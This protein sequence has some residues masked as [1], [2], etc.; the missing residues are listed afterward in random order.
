[1][2]IVIDYQGA[3]SS[4]SRDRGIGRYTQSFVQ[5]LAKNHKDHELIIALNG[6]FSEHIDNIRQQFD[7]LI[8]NDN[9]VTWTPPDNVDFLTEINAS[10]RKS[11][12]LIYEAFLCSLEPNII[13]ITSL[14]EGSGD[15]A[16]TS[17]KRFNP[18]AL[19]A[20]ILYDLIPYIY[21]DIY[22][23]NPA[24]AAWY[25]SKIKHIR[26]SDLLLTISESSRQEAINFLGFEPSSVSNIS[27]AIEPN[28]SPALPSAVDSERLKQHFNISR[29]FI[30][31][32]G[33]IDHRKNI[34][35]L[36]RG[37]SQL[38]ECVRQKYQLVI[39]CSVHDFIEDKLLQ[40]GRDNGLHLDDLIFTGFV[41]DDD[42]LRLY[43][44]CEVFIFPSWHEGFGLPALEAMACGKAVIGSNVSSIPEVIGRAD[45]LFEANNDQA[46]TSK[47]EEVLLNE[48][49]KLELEQHALVQAQKFSWQQTAKE[50]VSVLEASVESKRLTTP[51]KQKLKPRLA[52]VSPLPPARSGISDYSADLLPT[53][54]DF[55]TIDLI[56]D[57]ENVDT[58]CLPQQCLIRSTDWLIK[59]A[60]DYDRVIYHFGNS[61]FHKHMFH[62]IQRIPGVVVLH[63]FY[64]SGAVNYI[65][66][67]PNP[68]L[69][70]TPE[71]YRSAGYTAVYDRYK[72]P[73][74][75]YNHAV[76]DAYPCNLTVL[77]N[78]LGVIS[79]SEY[80]R[81]LATD[82]YGDSAVKGWHVL[83][84]LRNPIDQCKNAARKA[85]GIE[86]DEF[87]VCTFG[88]LHRNKL[89]KELVSSWLDS[90]IAKS[91]KC[92]LIF[93]GDLPNNNYKDELHLLL[94]QSGQHNITITG[95]TEKEEYQHYLAAT[96]LCIQLRRTSRGE[97]SA[98]VLD[99]LSHGKATLVNRN[100]SM[101]E[102]DDEAIFKIPDDF[103]QAQ[104]A[105]ALDKLY[106]N[107]DLRERLG[108]AGRGLLLEKHSPVVCGN[109]YHHVI[110]GIYHKPP[111]HSAPVI[112]AIAKELANNT[113]KDVTTEVAIAIN[114]SF[115]PRIKPRQCLIDISAIID[116]QHTDVETENQF[117]QLLKQWVLTHSNHYRIEPVY[118]K[119]NCLY[120][121]RAFT[122]ELIN[123][124]TDALKD[125]PVEYF[126][127][128]EL[129]TLTSSRYSPRLSTAFYQATRSAGV[130]QTFFCYDL[131]PNTSDS[132]PI[133]NSVNNVAQWLPI[134]A[135]ADNIQLLSH[136]DS[137]YIDEI[138]ADTPLTDKISQL[139]LDAPPQRYSSKIIQR[140]HTK[141]I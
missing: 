131:A 139:S 21:P 69:R 38:Q 7:G 11:A 55:Y 58:N 40:L 107:P 52:F 130:I 42:L 83:P 14:F 63:D 39:V 26:Q 132:S 33:G 51:Q 105:A 48:Q 90:S 93:V 32:T 19:V 82:W 77:N 128:D 12:E 120:Y 134:L 30:M 53:L 72:D 97:T 54:L 122:L 59:H 3:Q 76:M 81:N 47:L 138:A 49:F 6:R 135:L 29:P 84:L 9:I 103:T 137:D 101:D 75:K 129:V 50:A 87:I 35:G 110:E 70:F 64:L 15:D 108:Q 5:A 67:R 10:R 61:S 27:T 20:T 88:M 37:Y 102:I 28:F 66:T 118:E 31:Y 125:S 68:G 95:W 25:H 80:S 57:Q 1:M 92:R 98:A 123:C 116:S 43:R 109:K 96:D 133:K 124:P 46:I 114:K 104:L 106:H 136:S 8:E 44:S 94:E 100:G 22:L 36:I 126:Q 99:C 79:H 60:D 2:R 34:E 121:A 74:D 91:E 17:I 4:G 13:L 111:Q 141:E 71:L 73:S 119:N 18:D 115:P 16:V 23:V 85:L 65:D 89:N 112:K 56:I 117:Q 86:N 127:G 24:I 78:A 62:L 113:N 41:H 140:I 45:A